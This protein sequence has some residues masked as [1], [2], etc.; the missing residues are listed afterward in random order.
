[1]LKAYS[2]E[3][4]LYNHYIINQH[5]INPGYTGFEENHQLYFNYKNVFSGFSETP[6]LY[7]LG[8]NGSVGNRVGLGA[9]LMIENEALYQ[10]LK[11]ALSYGYHFTIDDFKMGVGLTTEIHS[12]KLRNAYS[13]NNGFIDP[14]DPLINDAQDGSIYFDASIG[15]YGEYKNMFKFGLSVPNLA[16]TKISGKTVNGSD[17]LS[18]SS[19]PGFILFLGTKFMFE[20]K[21]FALEPSV[22]FK[23]L[24]RY[25]AP[26][27]VDVNLKGSFMDDKLVGGVSYRFAESGGLGVII[28]TKIDMIGLY[29]SYD[30]SFGQFQ[31]YNNGVHEISLMVKF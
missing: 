29:Y 4:A 23:K 12:N 8:Y 20:D 26:F 3:Q 9:N 10:R 27:G 14:D 7:T 15:V 24:N 25:D 5:L 1:M 19:K 11:G 18:S 31:S 17:T 22:C 2:Q 16:R 28:G 30:M 6:T 21:K 13:G